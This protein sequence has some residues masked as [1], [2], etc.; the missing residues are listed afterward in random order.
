MHFRADAGLHL[1][2][3]RARIGFL[4]LAAADVSSNTLVPPAPPQFFR[5][6]DYYLFA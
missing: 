4:H 2:N 3:L 1:G 6:D 5:Y